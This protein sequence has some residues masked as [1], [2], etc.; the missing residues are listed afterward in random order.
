MP[1]PDMLFS[2]FPF[3]KS[4]SQALYSHKESDDAFAS[5]QLGTHRRTF[6]TGAVNRSATLPS[7]FF[8]AS[9]LFAAWLAATERRSLIKT[10]KAA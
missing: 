7:Y 5:P 3:G 10:A 1:S 6:K 2:R 4:L 8:L 9:S